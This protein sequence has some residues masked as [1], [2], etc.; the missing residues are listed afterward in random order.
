MLRA[1]YEM[2]EQG[3]SQ[4]QLSEIT[5]L[6]RTSINRVMRGAQKPFP[7]WKTR[8][9]IALGWPSEKAD[10]LFEEIEVS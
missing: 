6:N 3:L 2:R 8:I 5:G 9:A 10:E 4:T 1:D 7:K